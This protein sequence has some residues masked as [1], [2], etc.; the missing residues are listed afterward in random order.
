[1]HVVIGIRQF[2]NFLRIISDSQNFL[3]I[4]A[5]MGPEKLQLSVIGGQDSPAVLQ[6]LK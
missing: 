2:L 1:M 5:Q 6:M 4:W 3:E